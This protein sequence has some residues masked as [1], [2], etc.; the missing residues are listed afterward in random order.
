MPL[1]PE[2][3]PENKAFWTGG[4]HGQLLIMHCDACDHAIHPPQLICPHCLSRSVTPRPAAGTGNVLSVTVN[5]QPWL[6]DQQVPSAIAIVELD[7]EKG[8]R[9]TGLV[10]DIDPADVAIGMAVETVFERVEDVWIP[11]FRPVGRMAD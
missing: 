7:G 5:H 6:P 3:T 4:E 2:I 8:V 1:L 11:R 10:I 9:M